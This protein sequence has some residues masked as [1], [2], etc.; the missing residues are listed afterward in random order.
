M[1]SALT[2][3]RD[4]ASRLLTIYEEH[5]D[6]K[7]EFMRRKATVELDRF[8]MENRE[9]AATLM[10][11]GLQGEI[12]ALVETKRKVPWYKKL[13]KGGADDGHNNH[14]RRDPVHPE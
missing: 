6:S 10:V 2:R 1:M 3:L 9:T 4:E 11:R 7:D 8:L 5:K 12:D 14:N 13:L